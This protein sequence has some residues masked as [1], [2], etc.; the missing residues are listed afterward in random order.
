MTIF[1]DDQDKHVFLERARAQFDGDSMAV[2]VWT[3]MRNHPHM[4]TRTEA[5]SL[6][7][8]MHRLGTGYAGYFN[9]RHDRKGHVYQNRFKS[10]LVEDEDYLFRLI[11]YVLLNP[12]RAGIVRDLEGLERY[13]WTAY[14]A[15]LGHS[16][17]L[18]GDPIAPLRLFADPPAAA[19]RELRH[20]LAAG[21]E[22]DDE[23][24]RLVERGPGRP[25][26]VVPGPDAAARVHVRDASVVGDAAFVASILKQS[27]HPQADAFERQSAGWLTDQIIDE[28]CAHL[29]VD[30][31]AIRTGRRGRA[32]EARAAIAWLAHTY[33]SVSLTDLAPQL[34]VSQPALSYA[35]DKG[36]AVASAELG[37]LEDQLAICT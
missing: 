16:R 20:W 10:I 25:Q 2:L 8:A 26:I 27:G 11:R 4:F 15:L 19:Q 13:R 23:I 18:L 37:P 9:R 14:P 32:S 33:L 6:S 21:L 29:L 35:L 36:R 30:P 22:G 17:P 12:L 5:G 34:G 7:K 3:L 1:T 24:H 28:V 31:R